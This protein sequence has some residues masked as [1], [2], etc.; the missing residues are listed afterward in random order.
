ML[1]IAT[2]N[3]L[4]GYYKDKVLKNIQILVE[5]GADVICLQE[6]EP[7]FEDVLTHL[8]KNRNRKVIYYHHSIGCN[9]ATIYNPAQLTLENSEHFLLPK[10]SNPGWRQRF[11]NFHS[12][13]IQRGALSVYFMKD[14]KIIRITNT[15]MAWEGGD[16]NRISQFECIK[17]TLSKKSTDCDILLGDFNTFSLA[18]FYRTKEKK[19][20]TT[21]RDWT[22]VLKSLHWTCDSSFTSPTDGLTKFAKIGKIFGIKFRCKLDY[23]FTKNLK[24]IS[25]EMLDLPGSDH[26]PLIADF[27]F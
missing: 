26:R 2:Y 18:L 13:I 15:H 1:K 22:N 25:K 27:E 9:L 11:T 14:S 8:V 10:L 7:E 21:L 24:V 12:E 17:E 16:K 20:E 4:H 6:V 3:I 23:I 5:G 19:V